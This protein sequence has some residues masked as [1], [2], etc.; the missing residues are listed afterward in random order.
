MNSSPIHR[1]LE[2]EVVPTQAPRRITLLA[3]LDRRVLSGH[4]HSLGAGGASAVFGQ[5]VSKALV[6]EMTDQLRGDGATDSAIGEWA[7]DII[8]AFLSGE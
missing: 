4:R 2:E 7:S 6:E 3:E 8:G 1:P 5:A